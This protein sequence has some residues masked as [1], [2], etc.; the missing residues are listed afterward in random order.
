MQ[1]CVVG[2]NAKE[3]RR[4]EEVALWR[5]VESRAVQVGAVLKQTEQPVKRVG[6]LVPSPVGV[7]QSEDG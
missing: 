3:S 4:K 6:Q 5:L 1:R 7:E 2:T